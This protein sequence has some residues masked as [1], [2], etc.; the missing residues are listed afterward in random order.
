[1]KKLSIFLAGLVA[2]FGLASC[3]NEKEPVYKAPTTFELN[4]PVMENQYLELNEENTFELVASAQPDYGYSAVT[5]YSALVSLTPDFTETYEMQSTEGGTQSRMVFKGSDLA[6]AIC[7]LKGIASQDD[8]VDE[9]AIEVYFKGVAQLEGIESSRIVSSNYVSLKQVKYYYA[10]KTPGFIYLVGNL[11]GWNEPS[12]GN[13]DHYAQY[14]LYEKDDAIGSK[15]YF[16]TFDVPADGVFRFYTEL[17]GWD[18]GASMGAQVEDNALTFEMTDNAF[19]GSIMKGKG[20]YQFSNWAGG[21]MT[22][23]V[24]LAENTVT[25]IG[26]EAEI[27]VVKYVY[28]LGNNAGWA[29]PEAANEETYANWRLVDDNEDGIYEGTFAMDGIENDELY[30]RFKSALDGSWVADWSSDATGANVDV[31]SGQSMPTYQGEGCFKL[32]GVN[33]HNLTIVLDTNNANVTFTLD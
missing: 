3:E 4:V 22:M 18:G 26:G 12:E 13:K 24:N 8:Y 33:G 23:C 28:I 30:C 29:A 19:E 32:A 20:S 17:T 15:I 27:A 25:F 21:K 11:T 5:T 9:P 14:R 7:T 16:G 10:V 1:M 6:L 2:V 31:V